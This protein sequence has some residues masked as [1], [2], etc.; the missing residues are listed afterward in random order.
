MTT[1]DLRTAVLS[2]PFNVVLIALIAS[3]AVAC[4]TAAPPPGTSATPVS[5]GTLPADSSGTTTTSGLPDAASTAGAVTVE[6]LM[7]S[8]KSGD[9]SLEV[10]VHEVH[11]CPPCPP[12]L[13]C[14]PCVGERVEVGDGAPAAGQTA[15]L[16]T[17]FV[18]EAEMPKLQKGKRFRLTV[19]INRKDPSAAGLNRA[20]LV[21]IEASLP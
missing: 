2:T 17:V 4:G 1:R 19:A 18:G 5:S 11:P 12:N 6:Q 8:P 20:D 10:W 15:K 9:I 14:R 7:A 3:S 13:D 21:R 16:L